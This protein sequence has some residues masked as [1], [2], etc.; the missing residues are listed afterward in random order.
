MLKNLLRNILN[1]SLVFLRNRIELLIPFAKINKAEGLN[2][3]LTCLSWS[4]TR[5]KT[6]F[7]VFEKQKNMLGSRVKNIGKLK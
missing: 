1:N 6:H 5:G 3:Q 4:F 2:K 7:S